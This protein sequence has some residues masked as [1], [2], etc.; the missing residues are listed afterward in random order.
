MLGIRPFC[1]QSKHGKRRVYLRTL[2]RQRVIVLPRKLGIGVVD[3]VAEQLL[4]FRVRDARVER[5]G[6]HVSVVAI[7]VLADR[8]FHKVRAAERRQGVVL[9]DVLRTDRTWESWQTR[10]FS[11]DKQAVNRVR[12]GARRTRRSGSG[13]ASD[14]SRRLVLVFLLL[15]A[16]RAIRVVFRLLLLLGNSWF[17]SWLRKVLPEGG[18]LVVIRQ[19]RVTEVTVFLGLEHRE[20]LNGNFE[21][22]G[23][24]VL[25][26]VTGFAVGTGSEIGDGVP[27]FLDVVQVVSDEV[28]VGVRPFR[29]LFDHM[30]E[31][32]HVE[33]VGP[34]FE[35][36]ANECFVLDGVLQHE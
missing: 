27:G 33:T 1:V 5:I 6:V 26:L 8:T 29:D 17:A 14:R 18:H 31:H 21:E 20:V 24:T 9:H 25:L 23:Q 11:G 30:F 2:W 16:V 10:T 22:L 32:V 19:V 15:L 4:V 36:A 7:L 35:L 12:F 34:K 3:K 28:L 13:A